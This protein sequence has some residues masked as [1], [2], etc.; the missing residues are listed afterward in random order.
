MEKSPQ[1]GHVHSGRAGDSRDG[2]TSLQPAREFGPESIL[3][4]LFFSSAHGVI[5]PTI[6][7]IVNK[8]FWKLSADMLPVSEFPPAGKIGF[9][10]ELPMQAGPAAPALGN[11]SYELA[12]RRKAAQI[13]TYQPQECP[14]SSF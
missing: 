3:N 8:Q 14:V 12:G 2:R 1:P 6:L 7:E 4:T 13:R 9:A 11:A 5:I 10:G